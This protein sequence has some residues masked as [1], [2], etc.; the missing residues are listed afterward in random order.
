MTPPS[1]ASSHKPLNAVVIGVGRMGQHHARN[2]SKIPGFSLLAVVDKNPESAAKVAAQYNCRA[3][4]S[5]DELLAF[6]RETHTPIH[7]ASA[8]LPTIF[9]REAAEK[10]LAVGAD[11]LIEKP[12]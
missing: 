4:A 9:H 10:L 5:V 11:V 12:L 1:P 3:F 6:S 8:A 2:Y 7:A